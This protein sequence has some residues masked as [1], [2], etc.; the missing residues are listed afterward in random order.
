[1]NACITARDESPIQCTDDLNVT[2][3]DI[4][5]KLNLI[6][7]FNQPDEQKN[8]LTDLSDVFKEQKL[9]KLKSVPN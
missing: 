4:R 3:P 8:I 1:M 5:V 9:K 6:E 7:N 2:A